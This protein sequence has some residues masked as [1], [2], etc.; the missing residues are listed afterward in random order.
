MTYKLIA[1]DMDGTLLNEQL[2][3]SDRTQKAL[4]AAKKKGIYVTLATGRMYCSALPFAQGL[5]LDV[6]LI[7]Y[8]GALIKDACTEETYYH[9]PVFYEAALTVIELAEA[10]G[11][12]INVYLDDKLYVQEIEERTKLYLKIANVPAYPVGRLSSFLKAAPTKILVIGEPEELRELQQAI[13]KKLGQQVEI[14]KSKPFFLEI[15]SCH[16]S[17][18]KALASLAEKWGIEREEIMAFGDNYNDLSMLD[19]AGLGVAMGNAPDD[20]KQKADLVAESNEEDGMAKV[21]E[22]MVL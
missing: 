22:R 19:Y 8:N 3:I 11:L 16:A 18:G 9:E 5:Q 21:I 12:H 2:K 13:Q 20:V 14:T 17:K 15:I 7:T 10:R 1:M 6:P 4:H